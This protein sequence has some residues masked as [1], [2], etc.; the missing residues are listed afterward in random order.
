MGR[1]DDARR[2]VQRERHV[3]VAARARVAAMD[4][5][6]HAHRHL[7]RP[8]GIRQ[9]ALGLHRGADRVRGLAERDEEGVALG[10]QLVAVVL[11]PGSSQQRMVLVEELLVGLAQLPK[12]PR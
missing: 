3:R 1:V 5:D 2:L 6:P 8:R 4:A 11:A 10:L 12:Q 7:G 9:R